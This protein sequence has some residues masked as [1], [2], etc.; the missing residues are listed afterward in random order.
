MPTRKYEKVVSLK[1]IKVACR[2]C[3]LNEICLP[4]GVGPDDLERLDAII[5]RKRPLS[6]GDHLFRNGDR[7]QSLYAVRS[8][9]LKTYATSADGQEQVM[10]FLLPGE[11][12]GLDAIA[13]GHHPLSAKTLE[14]TSVCEI[15]F[16]QLE[17]LSGQ[18]PGL[19][20]ELLRVMSQEIRDDEQNMVVLGQKSAEERLAAFLIGLSN[21][22]RRRGFS[23]NEFNLSMSR[24]DIGNYLGLALETVSRL[25]TRFQN[26]EL[27]RVDRKH[28]ELLDRDRL[29]AYSGSRCSEQRPPQESSGR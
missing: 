18:L 14:T 4:V 20:H 12:V 27:L 2:E 24:G 28:I 5:D 19:Q 15:P 3:S 16:T 17:S 11:L 10:G 23:P 26:E 29:C 8:G 13:D 25:F 21:R 6:R 9:S 22:F 1:D 7:F